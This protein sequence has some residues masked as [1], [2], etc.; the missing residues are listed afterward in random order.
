VVYCPATRVSRPT[1]LIPVVFPE[2]DLYPM[3]DIHPEAL[4]SFD[5]VLSGYWELP[6]HRSSDEGRE[7]H[8]TEAEA[9]L[10][11]MAAQFSH[12][13]V[14]TDVRLQFGP[15]GTAERHHQNVV[16][17]TGAAGILLAEQLPS[18]LNVLVPLRG[19]RHQ[20]EI[21]DFVSTFDADSLFV[22]ELYH[23][24]PDEAAVD[25]AEEMLGEVRDTLLSRGF[26]AADIETTVEVTGDA[27]AA[28]AARARDHHLVVLGETEEDDAEDQL[29]GPVC[30]YIAR[31]SE[32][33]IVV[34]QGA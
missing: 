28:I 29:F 5:V 4:G 33:P 32:T 15:A 3:T 25:S 18:L 16:E 10:Y 17:E 21:V 9:V 31:E 13:G 27:R 12:A 8:E 20:D 34:V 19:V 30:A 2:P 1:L 23:A 26:S 14:S 22:V 6:E 11:E 7:T 24:A